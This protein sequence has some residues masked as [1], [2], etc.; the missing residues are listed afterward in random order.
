LS[1]SAKPP[2]A[3]LDQIIGLYNQGELEQTVSL[4][5]SLAGQYP[6]TLLLY[7]ILGAAYMG[8][9]DT[10]KTIESYQKVLQLNPN[11]TD[12][13]NNMGMALYDRG[14]F[15]E[16]VESY[17]KAIN[18]EPDFADAYYNLGN[19][20]KQTGDLKQTIESYKA[21]LA[22]NPNDADVLLNFGNALKSYGDFDQAIKAYDH[23]L[24][25]NPD[26]TGVQINLDN[27]SEQKTELEKIVT[28]FASASKV[29]IGSAE[30]MNFIAT[31]LLKRGYPDAAIDNY[32]QAIK[33][34]P[35]FADAYYNMGIAFQERGKL[36]AAIN[37]Y[38]HAI[39]IKPSYAQA[40]YNMGIA[41][42]DKGEVT[43]AIESYIRAIKIKPDFADAY[44]NIGIVLMD[45]KFSRSNANLSDIILN[46]LNEKGSL[47]PSDIAPAAIR[48]IKLD[49]VFQSILNRY[50]KGELEQK[51]KDSVSKLSKITL[52]LKLME[53]CP[54]ADLEIEWLL[55]YLRS[56]IL[57]NF[58]SL[59]GSTET[60]KV[61]TAIALQCYTN[62]YIYVQT[63]EDTKIL[64]QL[65]NTVCKDLFDQKQ[66]N[67]LALA[68][69]ASYKA[70]PDYPWGHLIA[71][72]ANLKQLEKRQIS[73]LKKET[74][75]RPTIPILTEITD[76]VSSKV[77]LQYEQHP[78]PRWV[79]MGIT[80]APK[81]ICEIAKR[82]NLKVADDSIFEC[83]SPQILVAGCG[84]GQHS[85]G[86]AA[87][88][89]NCNVLAID[90]SIKSLA[91]S[92]R[93]TE[94][95]GIKNI[96]YM[97]ADILDLG[98]LDKKF[99]LIESAG[100]LH[101]MCDPL[102]GWKVLYECLKP[103]GMMK[104]G[105]YSELARQHVVKLREE[106]KVANLDFK[107]CTIKSFRAD[108]INSN[109]KHHKHILSMSDFYSL[110]ELRDL[111]FHVQEHRLTLPQIKNYLA[112]FGLKFCGFESLD[113]L[114]QFK[115]TYKG[116]DDLYDLDKWNTFEQDN[117]RTFVGMY[118]FWCQKVL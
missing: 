111:L 4:A 22:I 105:L 16:A 102:A 54:I 66:P 109:C 85:I 87:R 23:A 14:R 21:C 116:L 11:H 80:F 51:L 13:Y 32:K 43:K 112:E 57:S 93:K 19:A 63:D 55:T 41:Q 69:L 101:H 18:L 27:A 108:V 104:I 89:K 95:L 25:L 71:L 117:P 38:K 99:D 33:I 28:D 90:L 10:D 34:K 49:E 61:Q 50:F 24:K 29:E 7:D 75:L 6:N 5:E 84:T 103:G 82:I 46:L 3:V 88:F 9:N 62:E 79:N 118:Q 98:K 92:K 20:L 77:R 83:N 53:V 8:L 60:L 17:Q 72:P 58:F 36:E 68:C 12:A 86:T 45:V 30:T 31:I 40:Y 48:L 64:D 1:N 59:S 52:L 76:N 35:D 94:E 113:I 78:Y 39:D 91:Y 2:Q 56:E 73:E 70:L 67:P 74:L 96:K 110:S 26:L 47:R 97:Q 65:E 100:V 115:L 44:N 81:T 42:E 106:I 114:E 15:D 37:N 107:N